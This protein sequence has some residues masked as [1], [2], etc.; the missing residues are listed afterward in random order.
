[1]NRELKEVVN[2]FKCNKL[3]LNATKTSTN[4]M[5]FGT[6]HQINNITN[7]NHI[8]LDGRK[9]TRVYEAK[10]LGITLDHNLTWRS[11]I[12]SICKTCCRNIGV[13]NKLK[14]F[15]PKPNM[16]QLYYTL[17]LPFLTYGILL[18]GNANR[19]RLD[20]IVKLQKKSCKDYYK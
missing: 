8:Y 14:H 1:M 3:S 18:W 10:F 19:N 6:P 16:Y 12:N 11:H 15:L 17:I 7:D 5:F 13:L 2:W 20:R 4:L 9:L